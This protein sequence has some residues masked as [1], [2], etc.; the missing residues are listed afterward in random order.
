MVGNHEIDQQ[1]R[2]VIG[3]VLRHPA[4]NGLLRQRPQIALDREL[5]IPA[6]LIDHDA[7]LERHRVQHARTEADIGEELLPV[8]PDQQQHVRARPRSLRLDPGHP[9]L[10]LEADPLEDRGEQQRVFVAV[11]TASPSDQLA[12]DRVELDPGMG[13]ENHVDVLER[14]RPDM[15]RVQ[16]V[17]G[18]RGGGDARMA[19]PLQVGVKVEALGLPA[20]ARHD[21]T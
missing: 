21:S 5:V 16:A 20:H 10:H 4:V 19:D 2:F 15:R 17:Q 3:R 9:A 8:D 12:L 14:D 7:I 1:L 11:P 6:C 13:A 18:F